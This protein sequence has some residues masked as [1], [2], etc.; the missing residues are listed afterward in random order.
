MATEAHST[1]AYALQCSGL[2]ASYAP[3]QVLRDISFRARSGHLLAILG[4]N[5]AGKSSLLGAL[6]GIVKSTGSVRVHGRELGHVRASRRA[7]HGISLVPERRDNIFPTLSVEENVQ[8]GLRLLPRVDRSEREEQLLQMFP[9]LRSRWSAMAGMM[10]GGEQQMLSVA[11]ALGRKPGVLLLD[12]PTQGLA[13][14][15]FDILEEAFVTLKRSGMTLLLAEQNVS[16][17]RRMADEFLVLSQGEITRRGVGAD[18]INDEQV[19]ADL[20]GA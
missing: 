2:A 13:P 20:L 15:V 6:A 9:V 18:L 8:I 10:S 1:G 17:A 12:E 19:A 4:V 14:S 16:F 5:G 3:I 7:V 11:M